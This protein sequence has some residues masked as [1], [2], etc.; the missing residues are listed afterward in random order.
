VTSWVILNTGYYSWGKHNNFRPDELMAKR[1]TLQT[2][3]YYQRLYQ[4]IRNKWSNN[5]PNFLWY[6]L[7]NMLLSVII[8]AYTKKAPSQTDPNSSKPSQI[9]TQTDPNTHLNRPKLAQIHSHRPKLTQ[10]ESNRPKL[11]HQIHSYR[12]KPT[13]NN[14]K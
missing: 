2:C 8:T 3:L 6:F 11:T 1:T 4:R 13:Q 14:T 10:I 12:L 5:S 7:F 9:P